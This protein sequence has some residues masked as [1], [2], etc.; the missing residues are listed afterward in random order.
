MGRSI[1]KR[2]SGPVSRTP[3]GTIPDLQSSHCL[4]SLPCPSTSIFVHAT[5]G[6]RHASGPVSV[7]ACPLHAGWAK[8]PISLVRSD[9]M[10]SISCAIASFLRLK[11]LLGTHNDITPHSHHLD[12]KRLPE[13]KRTLANKQYKSHRRVGLPSDIIQSLAT[14]DGQ[15]SL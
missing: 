3:N 4:S 8:A 1:L 13:K 5:R 2:L 7:R 6:R 12:T 14:H 9:T 10:S 15:K 11:H